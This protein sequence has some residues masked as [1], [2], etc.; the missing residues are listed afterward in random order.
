MITKALVTHLILWPSLVI[1]LLTALGMSGCPRYRVWQ[2]EMEGTAELKRAE[3][4]R[5]VKIAEAEAFRDSSILYAE[6]EVARARGVAESN[7][8]IA[9]RLGGPEAYLRYLW[10]QQLEKAH[11]TIYI[12]TEA[13]LPIL[14]ATRLNTP[15]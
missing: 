12:P 13:N 8:I 11:N 2:Q 14:E 9:E 3:Q 1:V 15:R 7:D 4:N 5:Q 10:I 6:A